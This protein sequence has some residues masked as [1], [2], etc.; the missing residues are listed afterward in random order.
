V[1]RSSDYLILVVL[2]Q[3][4]SSLDSHTPKLSSP[5]DPDRRGLAAGPAGAA[6]RGEEWG[7]CSICCGDSGAVPAA[8]S[9]GEERPAAGAGGEGRG[10][11][12]ETAGE[13]GRGD[14]GDS[15][16]TA[17]IA[18]VRQCLIYPE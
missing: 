14:E 12:P 17:G 9:G 2:H 7:T 3:S 11:G 16:E 18:R 8:R 10:S 1:H 4:N 13:P 5:Q 6:R 15:R